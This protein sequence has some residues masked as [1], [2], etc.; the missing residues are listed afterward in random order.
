MHSDTSSFKAVN[1]PF[2]E[3]I[4]TFDKKM[5]HSKGS[6]LTRMNLCSL[7]QEQSFMEEKLSIVYGGITNE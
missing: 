2:L 5:I 1:D 6:E 3:N 4:I 7:L